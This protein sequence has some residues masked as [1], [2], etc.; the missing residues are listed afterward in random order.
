MSII[1]H[2][3]FFFDYFRSTRKIYHTGLLTDFFY[4]FRIVFFWWHITKSSFIGNSDMVLSHAVEI[5]MRTIVVWW[6]TCIVMVFVEIWLNSSNDNIWL[7]HPWDIHLVTHLVEPDITDIEKFIKYTALIGLNGRN[8][9]KFCE[10]RVL[11]KYRPTH[12]YDTSV[13]D[14]PDITVPVQ[15]LVQ[16]DKKEH[17]Y[18]CLKYP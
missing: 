14:N 9:M 1:M 11:H 13:S 5:D 12:I 8:I 7:I 18:I 6:M 17:K 10:S 15:Y 2:M 16:H 3:S 4:K